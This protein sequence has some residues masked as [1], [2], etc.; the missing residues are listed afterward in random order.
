[1]IAALIALHLL[2]PA[3][4]PDLDLA[5]ATAQVESDRDPTA[6]E[7]PLEPRARTARRHHDDPRWATPA[8]P[9]FCGLLQ[10]TATS[11]TECLAQR[12][13]AVEIAAWRAQRTAWRRICRQRGAPDVELCTIAGYAVGGAG[14]TAAVGGDAGPRGRRGVAYAR[15]LLR[16]ARGAS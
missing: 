14:V 16:R 10:T 4:G 6:T 12:T 15:A 1:V 7:C 5:A 3:P 8:R 13:P 11:P 2:T 9:C